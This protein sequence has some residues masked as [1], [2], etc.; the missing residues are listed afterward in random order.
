MVKISREK[1][2]HS[3]AVR[4]L[5]VGDISLRGRYEDQP[6]IHPFRILKSYSKRVSFV[7]G[8]LESPLTDTG[9]QP[10]PGKCTLRGWLGWA[11]V[12][13]GVGVALVCV[14]NNHMMDYGDKGLSST[15]EVLDRF[16]L[17]YVGAGKNLQ[18]AAKPVIL[19]LRDYKVA[20]LGRSSVEVSS[21]CYAHADEPG[22]AW[23]DKDE[24]KRSIRACRREADFVVVCLHWGMEHYQ[25]PSPSQR[26]FARELAEAGA[27]LILGHHPHVLQG[28][29]RIGR[30][31]VSYSS[32]NFL[33]DEFDWSVPDGKGGERTFRSTLTEKNRQG[34]MLEISID[35]DG[36]ISSRPIF[37]RISKSAIVELDDTPDRHAEYMRLC[38]RLTMPMPLYSIFWKLYSMKQEWNLRFSNQLSPL[39]VIRKIHKIRPR[40]FKELAVK[41]R[42]SARVASEKSTN[43]YEG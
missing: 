14:A 33:F 24:L 36:G 7:I 27:D 25:Y 13:N 17:L 22:V 5:S 38:S 40:H 12:L 10:V 1:E 30:T 23:L 43:P 9:A 29:E 15:M 39:N 16:G 4:F 32:G 8:N 26:A 37:T 2:L 20:F 28:E 3:S 34:M 19:E 35:S 41:I 11:S 21:K 31:L 42:R 6:D 18:E